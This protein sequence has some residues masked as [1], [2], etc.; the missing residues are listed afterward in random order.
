MADLP[1]GAGSARWSTPCSRRPTTAADLRA[2][3][4]RRVRTELDRHP[5]PAVDPDALADAS[6]P[7]PAPRSARSPPTAA[8]PTRASDRLA[9]LDFELPLAGGDTPARTSGSATSSHCCA[10]TCTR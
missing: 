2:E 7:S 6:S 5:T 8:S 10:A 4:L 3:L 1:V 9:E